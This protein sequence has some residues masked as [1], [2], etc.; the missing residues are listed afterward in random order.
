[1]TKFF[2]SAT[3]AISLVVSAPASARPADGNLLSNLMAQ[4]GASPAPA[5]QS[6]AT[7]QPAP[8]TRSTYRDGPTQSQIAYAM[9]AREQAVRMCRRGN[10]NDQLSRMATN[11]GQQLLGS[12]ITRVVNGRGYG[13]YYNH[14]YN[15]YN[16]PSSQNCDQLGQEVYRDALTAQPDSYCDS[17]MEATYT[18]GGQPVTEERMVRRCQARRADTTW[19]TSFQPR[20]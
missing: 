14:S 17:S 19:D 6:Q 18:R 4:Q 9:A 7:P 2:V 15:N 3:L 10:M 1:M 12:I 20:P 13:G 8:A 11:T 16:T 5:N